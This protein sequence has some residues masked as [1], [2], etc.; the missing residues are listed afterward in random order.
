[1]WVGDVASSLYEYLKPTIKRNKVFSERQC[2]S[3]D[4]LDLIQVSFSNKASLCVSIGEKTDEDAHMRRFVQRSSW[5]A[6]KPFCYCGRK[7]IVTN[8]VV[9][10]RHWVTEASCSPMC[11][12]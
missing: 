5:C 11:A 1:M 8:F 9:E 4:S 10:V 2:V 6:G 3:C 7:C 12:I